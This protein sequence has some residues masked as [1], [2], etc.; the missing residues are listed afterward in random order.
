MPDTI[1]QK[2]YGGNPTVVQLPQ[3]L[4]SKLL[5]LAKFSMQAKKE[6]EYT[7]SDT[8]PVPEAYRGGS[9]YISSAT[10]TKVTVVMSLVESP[11]TFI[12][13]YLDPG[14]HPLNVYQ[15]KATGTTTSGITY[16][17]QL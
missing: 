9:L 6:Y 7:P 13:R 2:P 15:I 4:Q 5:D 12:T 14:Y 11:T 1:T 17:I 8:V 10:F 16:I 3:P